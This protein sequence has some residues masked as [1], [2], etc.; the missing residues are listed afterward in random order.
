VRPGKVLALARR[1]FASFWGGPTGALALLVFLGLEGLFFNDSVASY[2]LA[3]LGAM[4]RGGAF[5]ATLGMFS[6]GLSDLGLLLAL[7]SPL[8]TMRAFAGSAQGGHFDLLV[9][10]P[11]SGPELTL[12]LY[13]S[14]LASLSLLALLGLAPYALLLA[15]GVG[16]PALLLSSAIGLVLAVSAFAGLGLA[17]GSLTR[18]PVAT[19]LTTL[20]V[21]GFLWAVGWA[22][23]YLQGHAHAAAKALALGPRLAR[24]TLG[25]VDLNDALYFLALTVCPLAAARAGSR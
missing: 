25:L 8:A 14:A 24:F 21:L 15:M 11:L 17:V 10:F 4:A 3:N 20:G 18:K 7:V 9:T 1:E 19:A 13:A 12:G 5:D 23:P 16:S 2:A 6:V 22:A